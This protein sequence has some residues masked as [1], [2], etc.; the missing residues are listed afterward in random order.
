[1]KRSSALTL[2]VLGAVLPL[3]LLCS[4]CKRIDTA[5]TNPS[6]ASHR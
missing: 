4:G 3:C 2:F 5:L 6:S 1:M